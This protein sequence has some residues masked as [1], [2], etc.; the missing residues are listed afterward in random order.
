VATAW[1]ERTAAPQPGT[2]EKEP[3]ESSGLHRFKLK[4]F[5]DPRANRKPALGGK[6]ALNQTI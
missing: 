5:S 4:L 3:I 2:A 6:E 1:A